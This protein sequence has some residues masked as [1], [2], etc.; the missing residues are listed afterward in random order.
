MRSAASWTLV[1]CAAPRIQTDRSTTAPFPRYRT[2]AWASG[3]EASPPDLDASRLDGRIRKAVERQLAA[4]GYAPAPRD[5]ATLLV[6]YDVKAPAADV[7][8]SHLGVHDP[9]RSARDLARSGKIR[10]LRTA[11]LRASI[12]ANHEEE[13]TRIRTMR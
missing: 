12:H 13:T 6:D 5:E 2:F 11:T 7:F 3:P 8:P 10:R 9:N 1:A 4:K